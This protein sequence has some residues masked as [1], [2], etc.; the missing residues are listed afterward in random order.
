MIEQKILLLYDGSAVMERYE[1]ILTHNNL[2]FIKVESARLGRINLPAKENL[3]VLMGRG[4]SSRDLSLENWGV[5]EG[6][7][8]DPLFILILPEDDEGQVSEEPEVFGYLD[9]NSS[10]RVML[11]LLTRA[12]YYHDLRRKQMAMPPVFDSDLPLGKVKEPGV[13]RDIINGMNESV[14]LVSGSGDLLDVNQ[15]AIETLGYS[16]EEFRRIGLGAVDPKY[17]FEDV[18]R[19]FLSQPQKPMQVIDS[20]HVAK[21]GREIPVEIS[22]S[23]FS[24]NGAMA[25]LSIARDISERKEREQVLREQLKKDELVVKA[26]HHR[27]KNN[28]STVSS[29]LSLRARTSHNEEAQ[30]VLMEAMA[31]VQCIG[32]LYSKLLTTSDYEGVSLEEYLSGIGESLLDIYPERKNL[33]LLFEMDSLVLN[34][35]FLFPLGVIVEELLTNILKYSFNDQD[36]GIIRISEKTI[37]RHVTI[38]IEDNGEPLPE[39]FDYDNQKGFGM[40]IVKLLCKQLGGRLRLRRERGMMVR[41]ISFSL[42]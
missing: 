38:Y 39:D 5:R 2:P 21:D 29:L 27:I 9:E 34:E 13:Y 36:K 26:M 30:D 17:S 42:D 28:L 8:I 22:I 41:E 32:L 19:L 35:E 7:K 20:V 40:M 10:Q 18:R 23:L 16:R 11:G 24:Y 4:S 3:S 25:I 15:K 1:N 33:E 37:N 14:W 6:A 12:F 31:R